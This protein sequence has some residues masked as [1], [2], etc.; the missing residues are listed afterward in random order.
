[1]PVVK[2]N[3]WRSTSAPAMTAVALLCASAWVGADQAPVVGTMLAPHRDAVL[4]AGEWADVAWT[5]LPSRV[6]EFEILLSLDDGASFTLRLTPQLDPDVGRYR[7]LVPNLPTT[8]ARLQLRVGIEHHEVECPPGPLFTI[9]SGIGT[10]PTGMRWLDGEWWVSGF[11]WPSPPLMPREEAITLR[12]AAEPHVVGSLTS[13]EW[14]A[15][16]GAAQRGLDASCPASDPGKVVVS[17]ADRA[18]L[19]IPQRE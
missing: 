13:R 11:V 16:I 19:N 1:M 18:P 2:R 17:P 8:R 14:S 12:P 10:S 15:S 4:K 9:L 7:W 5:P 6:E 3:R